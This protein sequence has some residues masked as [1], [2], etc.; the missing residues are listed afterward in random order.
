MYKKSKNEVEKSITLPIGLRRHEYQKYFTIRSIKLWGFHLTLNVHAFQYYGI[1]L[2]K[3]D[4]SNNSIIEI[5]KKMT[6]HGV[7][8]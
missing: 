5:K 6:F 1:N 8:M 7:L 4:F 2:V 3:I